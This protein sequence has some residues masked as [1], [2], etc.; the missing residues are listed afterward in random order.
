MKMAKREAEK[1]INYANDLGVPMG[2][3]LFADIEPGYPVD[4][5]F[6]RGWL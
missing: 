6:I 5:E 3:A 2:V 4:S 1:A